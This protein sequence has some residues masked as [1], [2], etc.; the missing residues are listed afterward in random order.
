VARWWQHRQ[1]ASDQMSLTQ[2]NVYVLPT[3]AGLMLAITLVALLVG[4]IN[5]QLNLGYML[6][7]L[8]A[9][10]AAMALFAGHANLRGLSVALRQPDEVYAGSASTLHIDLTNAGRRPRHSVALRTYGSPQASMVDV[11]A[12]AMQGVSLAVPR[13]RRGEHALPLIVLESRFPMGAF[14]VWTVWRPRAT[15]LVY[16]APEPHPP[17]LPMGEAHAGQGGASAAPDWSE[18]DGVRPYR[19]GDP[20]KTL[21]WKKFAKSGELVSRDGQTSRQRQLWLDWARCGN[22]DGEARLS[23]LAAWILQADKL[24]L[25]YGLRLPGREVPPGLGPQ[26]RM[27]CLK[28]L[29]LW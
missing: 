15:Q 24:G 10:S 11:G 25:P 4:S 17:A 14:R 20:L 29:A 16:P 22:L 2:R 18:F 13:P 8:L 7:F 27:N 9:G 23:R 12:Q 21:L 5:Y 1:P 6:T 28:V 26:H 19:A 3:R